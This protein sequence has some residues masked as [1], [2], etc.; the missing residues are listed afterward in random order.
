MNSHSPMFS[1]DPQ[2]SFLNQ[3]HERLKPRQLTRPSGRWPSGCGISHAFML[4]VYPHILAGHSGWLC[5]CSCCCCCCCRYCC[6]Y[7]SYS[8]T[9]PC[10]NGDDGSQCPVDVIFRNMDRLNC[11][12][13]HEAIASWVGLY[14]PARWADHSPTSRHHT[15]LCCSPEITDCTRAFPALC[16]DGGMPVAI[17]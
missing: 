3:C 6:C 4:H 8:S 17:R 10:L 5:Y 11:A 14:D 2:P 7:A 1:L 12:L 9:S 15:D 16:L 13:A